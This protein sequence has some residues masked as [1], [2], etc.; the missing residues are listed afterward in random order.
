MILV[1]QGNG[2]GFFAAQHKKANRGIG[3]VVADQFLGS[4]ILGKGFA[5]DGDIFAGA[6]SALVSEKAWLR[7]K[8]CHCSSRMESGPYLNRDCEMGGEGVCRIPLEGAVI[9]AHLL[10]R[11]PN[12]SARDIDEIQ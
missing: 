5:D 11:T 1:A 10:K 7:L 8:A 4:E 6:D 2:L 3:D 9:P 12:Q